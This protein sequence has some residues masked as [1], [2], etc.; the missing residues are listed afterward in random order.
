MGVGYGDEGH[1]DI[2]MN[3]TDVHVTIMATRGLAWPNRQLLDVHP[4]SV[5]L[6]TSKTAHNN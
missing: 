3:S 1:V 2:L 4:N 5:E 6:V